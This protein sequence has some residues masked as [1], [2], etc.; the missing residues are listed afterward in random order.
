MADPVERTRD[1]YFDMALTFAG[2]QGNGTVAQML[3]ACAA[4]IFNFHEF[5]KDLQNTLVQTEQGRETLAVLTSEHRLV[6]GGQMVVGPYAAA[7]AFPFG[8]NDYKWKSANGM[9]WRIDAQ[10]V[11]RHMIVFY[12]YCTGDDYA[13]DSL[14]RTFLEYS[15]YYLRLTGRAEP[16]GLTTRTD[17]QAPLV[18]LLTQINGD[19]DEDDDR[20]VEIDEDWLVEWMSDPTLRGADDHGDRDGELDSVLSQQYPE[21]PAFGPGGGDDDDDDEDGGGGGGTRKLKPPKPKSLPML[22]YVPRYDEV[23]DSVK[24]ELIN[25][26]QKFDAVSDIED[27]YTALDKIVRQYV[28]GLPPK[29][30]AGRV[31]VDLDIATFPN[32]C[33]WHL[34]WFFDQPRGRR[35]L[36]KRQKPPAAAAPAPGE[37]GPSGGGD[38][39]NFQFADEDVVSDGGGGVSDGAFDFD[40]DELDGGDRSGL[41]DRRV[42]QRRRGPDEGYGPGADEDENDGDD[43]M[44][45]ADNPLELDRDQRFYRRNP[46]SDPYARAEPLIMP[47][48]RL[49]DRDKTR[50]LADKNEEFVEKV[51]REVDKAI[52]RMRAQGQ[53]AGIPTP[54]FVRDRLTLEET[55]RLEDAYVREGLDWRS[56]S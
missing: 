4:T 15:A 52:A 10:E 34:K 53:M 18:D 9:I 27:R 31:L 37:P 26:L 23:P 38:V 25:W 24:L 51:E 47:G 54:G 21:L 2:K 19:L 42:Q 50:S 22:T 33:L 40:E 28:P 7:S 12:S 32:V 39:E 46:D 6:F 55:K 20:F 14:Q 36:R 29:D 56:E 48:M 11:L 30:L 45:D 13:D 5:V 41:S 49:T 16:L 17:G 1:R 8:P 43:G 35:A 44:Y 3:D